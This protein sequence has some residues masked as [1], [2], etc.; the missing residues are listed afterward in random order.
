MINVDIKIPGKEYPIYITTDYMDLGKYITE[1]CGE[2][3]TFLITDSN[4]NKYQA[5]ECINDLKAN[6]HE[7]YTYVF[8]AGESAKNLETI[9]DIY[10]MLLEQNADRSSTLLALG[11]GVVGDITGFV[12][13]TYLRGINF[14]QIPTTILSQADSSVGGKV[15]VDFNGEKNIIGAFYQPKLVY[16]NVNSIRTLP[17]REISAGLAEVIKHGIIRDA[18]FYDYVSDNIDKVF[19][20]DNDVLLNIAKQDCIIK[21]KVVEADEKEAGIRAILNFGHTFGHAIESAYDFTLLHGE[22]VSLGIIAAFNMAVLLN[23]AVQ[24]DADKVAVTLT[25]AGLPIKLPDIDVKKVYS[26]MLHDKKMKAGKLKF[27]LP[28]KIGEVEMY[29]TDDENLIREVLKT[30][31]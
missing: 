23:L 9:E 31:K 18:D 30:L 19:N 2:G 6:G 10:T 22:C 3:K 21:G 20:F 26:H 29:T 16:I 8:Q 4:V 1:R 12:A 28:K 7:V 5:K 11:G 17:K 13:A 15:G 24:K 27:V 25:K 14:V